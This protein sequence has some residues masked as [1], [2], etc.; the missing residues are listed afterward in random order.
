MIS[1]LKEQLFTGWHF[2]RF[3]GLTLGI[4]FGLQALAFKEPFAGLVSFFFLF[5]VV[6]NTGCFGR[7]GCS[8]PNNSNIQSLDDVEFTEIKKD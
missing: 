4:I 1:I 8:V 7:N 5:Q 6:T 2:T 3:V